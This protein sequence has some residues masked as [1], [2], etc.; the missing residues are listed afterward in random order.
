MGR[1]WYVPEFQRPVAREQ[2]NRRDGKVIR[3]ERLELLSYK[4]A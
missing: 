4:L 1:R 3:T 2:V